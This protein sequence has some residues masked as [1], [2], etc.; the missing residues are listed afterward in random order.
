MAYQTPHEDKALGTYLR[1]IARVPLLT[2]EE[3]KAIARES[4]N[5]DE[6][7]IQRLV[8]AN[9][10]F[11]V[12]VAKQYR[13]RGLS[14]LDL[15][16]EGNI[17]LMKSARTFDPGRNVRFVSYAV[18]WIRQTILAALLDKADLVRI[19]QSQVKK[20]R[21][22]SKRVRALEE[23]KG[24]PLSDAE[25]MSKGGLTRQSVDDLK[26]FTQGYLSLD[27]TYVGE[28]EKPLMEFLKSNVDVDTFEKSMMDQSLTSHLQVA[29]RALSPRDGQILTWRYGLDGQET[30]TLDEIGRVLKI[31]K[32]RVRQIEERAVQKIRTSKEAETLR[33]FVN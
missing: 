24:S 15:I 28:G 9:L 8:E 26:R 33:D 5:G 21:K 32:E 7:A 20:M 30:R 29:L 6:K 3:E 23:K 25:A 18:W 11:V 19:P 2:P 31:S 16:N 17:G 14:F 22:A 27:T 10:R 13:N 1:E 12:S 4:Q